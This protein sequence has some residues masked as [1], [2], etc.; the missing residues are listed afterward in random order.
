MG[1][2]LTIVCATF[3]Y[4]F[5]IIILTLSF[6]DLLKWAGVAKDEGTDAGSGGHPE[7]VTDSEIASEA[8]MSPE[9]P[10]TMGATAG[11]PVD[12]TIGTKSRRCELSMCVMLWCNGTRCARHNIL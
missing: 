11:L 2:F 7:G 12:A 8:V 10:T 9:G 6:Q 1:L 3:E 5:I 4:D